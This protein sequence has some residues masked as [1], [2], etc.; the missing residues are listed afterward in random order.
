L[1][2][3]S[4]LLPPLG[5]ARVLSIPFITNDVKIGKGEELI[6]LSTPNKKEVKAKTRTWATSLK[7]EMAAPQKKAKTSD[8]EHMFHRVG[9]DNRGG[10]RVGSH[11]NI[12]QSHPK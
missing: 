12:M 1:L 6:M 8:D 2:S 7:G 4:V 3:I 10:V 11:A 5:T 9:P